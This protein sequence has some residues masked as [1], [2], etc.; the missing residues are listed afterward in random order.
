MRPVME[1]M[2]SY[3]SLITP[4]ALSLVD[5]ARMNEALD[6]QAENRY[7]FHNSR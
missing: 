5:L 2:C 1:R 6:V 7:R 4:G 3:E